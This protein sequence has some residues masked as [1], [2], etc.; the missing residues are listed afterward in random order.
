MLRATCSFSMSSSTIF[1]PLIVRCNYDDDK[2][3]IRRLDLAHD[4][5]EC[6]L[7]TTKAGESDALAMK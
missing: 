4:L 5:P 6:F 1:S 7:G 3:V 2:D